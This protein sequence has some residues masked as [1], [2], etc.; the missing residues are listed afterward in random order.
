MAHG[1]V[2]VSTGQACG[3][4]PT[5][6]LSEG[7][8]E[9]LFYMALAFMRGQTVADTAGS[10]IM[11]LKMA[12]VC[13]SGQMDGCTKANGCEA[14]SMVVEMLSQVRASNRKVTGLKAL[15]STIIKLGEGLIH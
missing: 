8:G 1:A 6:A 5:G 4:Q 11:T 13:S 10:I 12:L 9:T 7:S 3:K 2:T 14:S 15:T